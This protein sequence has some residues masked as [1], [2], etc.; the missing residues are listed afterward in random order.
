MVVERGVHASRSHNHFHSNHRRLSHE[1][2]YCERCAVRR[3]LG[4]RTGKCDY[5]WWGEWGYDEEFGD[6]FDGVLVESLVTLTKGGGET[7]TNG[8]VGWHGRSDS[9]WTVEENYQGYSN[10]VKHN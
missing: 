8:T 1:Q 3:T 10:K 6:Y 9:G 4:S 5:F 7:V 2:V